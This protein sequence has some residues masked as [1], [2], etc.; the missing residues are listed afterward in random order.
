MATIP[1]VF[2][3]V[4]VKKRRRAWK[5][6]THEE[7]VKPKEENVKEKCWETKEH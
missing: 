1:G 5:E 3:N 4:F 6:G 2:L 7:K